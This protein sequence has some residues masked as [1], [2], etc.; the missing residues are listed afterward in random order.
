MILEAVYLGQKMN[1]RNKA[2]IDWRTE[3]VPNDLNWFLQVSD[4]CASM[5]QTVLGAYTDKEVLVQTVRKSQSS[6]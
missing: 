2:M 4:I 5:Q 3:I 1:R 6:Q